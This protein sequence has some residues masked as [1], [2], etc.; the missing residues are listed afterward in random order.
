MLKFID[1]EKAT[2]FREIV[3]LLLPV[4]TVVKS[5]EKISQVAFSEYMNFT[6]YALSPL[7]TSTCILKTR[8][9]KIRFDE[10]DFNR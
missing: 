10:F 4:C 6:Y 8:V 2:K 1:S 5:K 9:L 3:P 7:L